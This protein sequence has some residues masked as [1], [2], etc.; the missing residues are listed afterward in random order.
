MDNIIP[1]TVEIS[2]PVTVENTENTTV[3]TSTLSIPGIAQNSSV[4][5]MQDMQN[6]LQGIMSAMQGQIAIFTL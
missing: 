6:R 4:S 5:A 2:I 3:D 1:V